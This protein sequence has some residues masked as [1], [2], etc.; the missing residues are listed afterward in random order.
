[1]IFLD[2]KSDIAFKKLFSN[3]KHT[4]IIINF[5]NNTLQR[6]KDSQIISVTINDPYNHPET[7][8]TKSSIVDVRCKD[9]NDAE[10]ILEMQVVNQHDFAERAQYYVAIALARQL[11]RSEEYIKLTPVIF[12]GIVNF[13]IFKTEAYISH[14]GTVDLETHERTMTF[15]EY[16]FIELKKFNKDLDKLDNDADKWVYFFKYAKDLETIPKELKKPLALTEAFTILEQ[17]NWTRKELEEYDRSLDELRIRNSQI[18]TAR[19]EGLLK[20]KIEGKLE[21]EK[22]KALVI[23]KNLLDVLDT[24]TIALKT[25][26]HVEEIELLKKI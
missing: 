18:K 8:F 16:H 17:G 10:Y 24:K 13:N 25:G 26:L 4:D 2:P 1:M 5:L 15:Q 11:Q 9:Q 7:Q 20:G 3:A 12:I 14:H 22:A 19:D 23:A 6:P 21:G